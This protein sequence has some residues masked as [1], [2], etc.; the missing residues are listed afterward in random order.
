M[1][2]T[3]PYNRYQYETSPRK[4]EPIKDP[5]RIPQKQKKSSAKTEKKSTEEIKKA[6]QV[7]KNNKIKLVVY[8][9]IGF[10]ILMAIGY[11]NS[12][13]NEA[14]TANQ[15][16]ERQI[17]EVQKENEQ[18]EVNIQNSLN[19]SQIEQEAKVRLGMQKL[20]SRQTVYVQLPKKDYVEAASEQVVIHDENKNIIDTVI[21]WIKDLF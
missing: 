7:E 6:K 8:L 9:F 5:K 2:A 15:K 17:S 16:L 10:G 18:L 4:I 20:N 11:R 3:R 13:I 19:L 21:D 14:F 1:P 12:Q